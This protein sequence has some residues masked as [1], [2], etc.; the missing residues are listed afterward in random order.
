MPRPANTRNLLISIQIFGCHRVLERFGRRLI[1]LSILHR[2]SLVIVPATN[3]MLCKYNQLGFLQA[4]CGILEM[5]EIISLTNG[6]CRLTIF[7]DLWIFGPDDRYL[8][9]AAITA[10]HRLVR[11]FGKCDAFNKPSKIS[12]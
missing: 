12:A 6:L 4:H 1:S 5:R 10:M 11:P 7:S 9:V 3:E 8:M 2:P